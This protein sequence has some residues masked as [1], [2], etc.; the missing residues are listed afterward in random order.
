MDYGLPSGS[1]AGNQG[2]KSVDRHDVA[3]KKIR[4]DRSPICDPAYLRR[5]DPVWMPGPVPA[6]FWEDG[7]NR[8]DYLLWSAHRLGFRT[9]EDLYRLKLRACYRRNYG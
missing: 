5:I 1:S 9:M 8:R 2:F 3:R 4:V 6:R 7:A